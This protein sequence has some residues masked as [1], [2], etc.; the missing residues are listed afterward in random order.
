VPPVLKWLVEEV[1]TDT[2]DVDV[3]ACEI[4]SAL[5]GDNVPEAVLAAVPVSDPLADV[6]ELVAPPALA[7]PSEYIED[8]DIRFESKSGID[9]FGLNA[10]SGSWVCFESSA[11]VPDA[12]RG[13][14]KS[15]TAISS[16]LILLLF[17][18]TPCFQISAVIEFRW[19]YVEE[20]LDLMGRSGVGIE[21]VAR[22]EWM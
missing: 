16:L 7:E 13:V 1:T 12:S 2:A 4:P 3:S 19:L 6:A 11:I 20:V 17:M 21:I 10:G 5:A 22:S 14:S 18:L 15:T 9:G 8:T